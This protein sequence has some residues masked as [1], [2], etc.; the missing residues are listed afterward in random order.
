M[1]INTSDIP[2]RTD[3]G[4]VFKEAI[5]NQAT[6]TSQLWLSGVVTDLEQLLKAISKD[7]AVDAG[8]MRPRLACDLKQM[9][10]TPLQCQAR[11]LKVRAT[12]ANQITDPRIG[13]HRVAFDDDR[14][15]F[16]SGRGQGDV[17]C[18]DDQRLLDGIA[19]GIDQYLKEST[20]SIGALDRRVKRR[21]A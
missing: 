6:F 21:D 19:A 8:S 11:E 14:A 3:A 5:F 7:A 12:D 16:I 15:G 2:L 18:A 10:P 13:T 20:V 17:R 1:S 9:I 4:G